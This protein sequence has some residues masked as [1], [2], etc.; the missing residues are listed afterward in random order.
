MN[1]FA[2]SPIGVPA[3]TAARSM[4]PVEICGMRELR[5]QALGLRS[6]ARARRT[7]QQHAARAHRPSLPRSRVPFTKPSYWRETRCASIWP[8][9][10]SATPTTISSAVPPK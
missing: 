5:D 8:I 1:A 9:V 2:S 3:F 10:S 6:L 7:Q 4:S